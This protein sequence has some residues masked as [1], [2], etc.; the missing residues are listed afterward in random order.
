MTTE[1]LRHRPRS[2]TETESP[3]RR[4]SVWLFAVALGSALAACSA[5]PPNPGPVDAGPPPCPE[6]KGII[7]TWAGTGEAGFNG[8]GIPL[9]RAMLYWPVDLSFDKANAGYVLDWNNHRVRRVKPDG[10]FETVVGT[11]FVG[12]GDDNQNDAKDPGGAPGTTIHLNHP[13]DVAFLADGTVLVASWHN[14]KIRA[15]NPATGMVKVLAGEG[16]GFDGDGSGVSKARFSQPSKLAVDASGQIFVLDQRNQ[17]VRR[18][19]VDAARTVTSPVGVGVAGFF[20]DGKAPTDAKLSFESGGNPEVNGAL[21]FDSSGLLYIADTQNHRI[22]RVDFKKNLIT[23]VAGS[24]EEGFAGDGGP[25]IK[26]SLSSPRDLAFGPDGKLYVADTNNH[27]VRVVDLATGA[28]ATAVGN[29]QEG[30]S[31][32]GAE[33]AKAQLRRPHGVAFDSKGA[34]YVS[35]TY[36]HRIRRVGP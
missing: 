9:P 27:A 21:A 22:R 8:D 4:L 26:A 16:P 6:Q 10:T 7:C 29:G 11:D 35:D 25:A 24:G 15:L 14:H 33:A 20:G 31:G 23:T 18:I 1:T 32:D 17:R 34:L 30:F 12:D 19:G 5:P 3:S 28:I 36:N 13:T 2:D